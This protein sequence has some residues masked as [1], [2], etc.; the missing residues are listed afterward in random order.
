MGK[1]IKEAGVAVG[2]PA[3]AVISM[4]IAF[5][6]FADILAIKIAMIGA[7]SFAVGTLV[8]PFT[9]TLRDMVH[10]TLGKA[11]ARWVVI[12][13]AILNVLMVLLFQLAI[14]LPASPNWGIQDEFAIVLGSVWRIVV[15]SI[16]A[17]L[18][19]QLIDTEVYSF[20]VN[21][22]TRK[23]QWGRVLLSNLISS[24]VDSIIFVSVAF[25]GILPM[26]IL[27]SLIV[28]QVI[29]KWVM[30]IVSIPGI[31]LVKDKDGVKM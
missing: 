14:V 10:K 16:L 27:W 11:G 25:L 12:M 5:Q 7:I 6:I 18:V 13:A 1:S 22:I 3:I 31:Y 30:A 17:E 2:A 26:P 20:Y 8:Y 28:V 19:S 29:V 9:F 24:P 4:Y 23:H 15:A 21:K